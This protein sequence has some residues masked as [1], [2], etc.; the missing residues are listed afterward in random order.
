MTQDLYARSAFAGQL[1]VATFDFSDFLERVGEDFADYVPLLQAG[2]T[3]VNSQIQGARVKLLLTGATPGASYL[4]GVRAT[5][6]DNHIDIQL[7]MLNVRGV[8]VSEPVTPPG[9]FLYLLNEA[10]EL[11]VTEGGEALYA[12]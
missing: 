10:G 4:Y 11:L 12:D 5:T 7:R 3:L 1:V 6:P 9:D 2:I 8:A